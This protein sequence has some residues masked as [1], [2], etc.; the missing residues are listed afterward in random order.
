MSNSAEQS[1][2]PTL[3]FDAAEVTAS[4]YTTHLVLATASPDGAARPLIHLVV[5]TAF[6][7]VLAATMLRAV[8]S[9]A[10]AAK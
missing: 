9:H 8:E 5:P 2:I 10:P 4:P 7:Q 6:A 3:Y 1:S